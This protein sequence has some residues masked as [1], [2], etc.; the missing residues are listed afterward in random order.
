MRKAHCPRQCP[1]ECRR[2]FPSTPLLFYERRATPYR[3]HAQAAQ[4]TPSAIGIKAHNDVLHSAKVDTTS[5]KTVKEHGATFATWDYTLYF[6][7]VVFSVVQKFVST[8][9]F[10]GFYQPLYQPF[11]SL[12]TLYQPYP[13]RNLLQVCTKMRI[14][15]FISFISSL[16]SARS[17][18]QS[19]YCRTRALAR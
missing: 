1:R 14:D 12:P 19:P 5:S 6:F 9:L 2:K 15:Y 11:L 10:W 8:N 3:A 4:T 7:S 13:I 18:F 16:I 17:G